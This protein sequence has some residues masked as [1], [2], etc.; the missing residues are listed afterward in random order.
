MEILKDYKV[1]LLA[2]IVV[3]FCEFIGK[4]SI[5]IITL[6]P[7]LYA[8]IIGGIISLPKFKIL[9][10]KNMNHASAIMMVTLM[11]LIAKLG[12]SVG[13]K[14]EMIL[15]DAKSALI[16]QELG[17]FAGTI[18]LGLPLA[19]MLGMK[20]EAVGATYSVAREPNIAI[21]ADKYGLDSA[22]GRGV[23]AMYICGTLYGAIWMSILASV[24]AK[25]DILHPYALAMGAGVGSGSMMAASLAPI[26]DL[27]P[28]ISED[29]KAYATTA[30]LMSSI[31]GIYIYT[32]FS[33]PFASFLYNTF[34]RL[35]RNCHKEGAL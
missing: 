22:E 27:Y 18:L 17:H 31:V 9:N 24:M 4:Q 20:R 33:L 5:W 28:E 21:V 7:M 26:S 23:M 14:I 13:P 8:M 3:L 19:M 35:R 11:L 1:H 16:F 30:N 25:L 29:I 2:M 15:E 6:Y 12:L 34:S 10:L 32:L